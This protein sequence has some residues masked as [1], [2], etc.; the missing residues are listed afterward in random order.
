MRPSETWCKST[1]KIKINQTINL[2]KENNL[3]ADLRY[4]VIFSALCP[5]V[6]HK[7]RCHSNIAQHHRCLLL[8]HDTDW[9]SKIQS[10]EKIK[11]VPH[12]HTALHGRW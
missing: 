12:F 2:E 1:T 5:A 4:T 6:S 3:H 11:S 7:M 10:L 8:T 9:G